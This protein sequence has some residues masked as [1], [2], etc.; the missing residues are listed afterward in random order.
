MRQDLRPLNVVELNTELFTDGRTA[1]KRFSVQAKRTNPNPGARERTKTS[2]DREHNSSA[3]LY[4]VT[5]TV[6]QYDDGAIATK[7]SDRDRDTVE[8]LHDRVG[9]ATCSGSISAT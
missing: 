4:G 5:R 1:C 2:V 3:V 6:Q 7:I 8:A 9:H